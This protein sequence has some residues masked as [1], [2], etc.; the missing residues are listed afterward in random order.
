MRGSTPPKRPSACRAPSSSSAGAAV[1]AAPLPPGS[2]TALAAAVRCRVA[3]ATYLPAPQREWNPLLHPPFTS[4]PTHPISISI[5]TY[6]ISSIQTCPI[7]LRGM[8]EAT[9]GCVKRLWA[10][11]RVRGVLVGEG[12]ELVDEAL[13]ALDARG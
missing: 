5:Q 7:S 8:S 10:A 6:P 4:I 11:G 1:G 2:G 9:Q 13:D 3:T 12:L